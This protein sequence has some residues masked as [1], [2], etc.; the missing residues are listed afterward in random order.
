MDQGSLIK[1]GVGVNQMN[2]EVHILLKLYIGIVLKSL[3][4]AMPFIHISTDT[5]NA[6]WC[7]RE[8]T[9]R[10][11]ETKPIPRSHLYEIA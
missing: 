7:A 11:S 1:T 4:Y 10:Y 9:Y 5:Y 2:R 8:F 6:S 3:K